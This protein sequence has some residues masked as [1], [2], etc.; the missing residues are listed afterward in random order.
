MKLLFQDE[1]DYVPGKTQRSEDKEKTALEMERLREERKIAQEQ[2]AIERANKPKREKP[3]PDPNQE[4]EVEAIKG[5]NSVVYFEY[6][7]PVTYLSY[8]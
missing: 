7:L 2:K 3:K 5:I 4:W 1:V 6:Y 8:L